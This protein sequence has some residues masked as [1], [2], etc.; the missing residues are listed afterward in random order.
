MLATGLVDSHSGNL[1]ARIPAGG[2][3]ATRSGT[4]L[5]ELCEE[6]LVAI[7]NLDDPPIGV[8]S[9]WLIHREVYRQVRGAGAVIHCHPRHAN[10]LAFVSERLLPIDTEA[11]T[12]VG[13]IPVL[14]L[15][16][17]VA[18]A[19]A[20]AA[21]AAAFAAGVAAVLLRRHGL[22]AWAETFDLALARTSAVEYAAHLLWLRR[23][24]GD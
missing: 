13:E 1:S 10:A 15:R 3:L 22:F 4:C 14:D 18:S 17:P 6:D 9:E 19:E 2:W 7:T 12:L 23:Q 24:L 20:A 21:V 8:T 16:Q 11:G 5:G